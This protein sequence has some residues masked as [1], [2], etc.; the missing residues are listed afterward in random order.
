METPAS[1]VWE[2][3]WQRMSGTVKGLRALCVKAATYFSS[4]SV[5]KGSVEVLWR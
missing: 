1:L 2:R 4:D 5:G 3:T